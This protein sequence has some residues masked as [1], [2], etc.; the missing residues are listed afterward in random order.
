MTM[1]AIFLP[2]LT[3]L[4]NTVAFQSVTSLPRMVPKS[5]ELK[6]MNWEDIMFNAQSTASSMASTSLD[7]PSNIA[8]SIPIMYGAGLLTAFSPCVWGLLPLTISYISTAAG[9]RK[10]K[11][12]TSTN[13]IVCVGS[14]ICILFSWTRRCNSRGSGVRQQWQYEYN[15]SH[16]FK[17]DMLCHGIAAFRACKYS[18]S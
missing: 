15:T 9:E 16:F 18:P 12:N 4:S 13:V 1:I 7:D 2:F 3:C 10:D 6:M 11:K 8:S 17:L 14:C 5:S